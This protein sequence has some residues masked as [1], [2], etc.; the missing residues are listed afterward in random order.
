MR[1]IVTTND[2][3]LNNLPTREI[4][5]VETSQKENQPSST[6]QHHQKLRY[7]AYSR[8]REAIKKHQ[9]EDNSYYYSNASLSDQWPEGGGQYGTGARYDT[10]DDRTN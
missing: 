8:H 1:T 6:D 10:N 2:D 7:N 4:S 3:P 5:M 9:T